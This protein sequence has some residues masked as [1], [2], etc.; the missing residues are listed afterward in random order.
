MKREVAINQTSRDRKRFELSFSSCI[1][2]F[3]PQNLTSQCP[4]RSF[5][6]YYYHINIFS[7]LG[8]AYFPF[9]SFKCNNTHR[10][11]LIPNKLLRFA[12]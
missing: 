8:Y 9:L 4:G 2:Y 10:N 1:L 12:Y 3:A 6:M 5:S 7:V 11:E